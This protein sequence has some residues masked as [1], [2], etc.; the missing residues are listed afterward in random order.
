MTFLED[1]GLGPVRQ[2]AVGAA[3]LVGVLT[4]LIL[5][6]GDMLLGVSDLL[7]SITALIQ[8]RFGAELGFIEPELAR[9]AFLLVAALYLA[10]LLFTLYDRVTEENE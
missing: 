1:I 2:L 10:N 4:D 6:G 5:T 9:K 3:S 8:G 7:F